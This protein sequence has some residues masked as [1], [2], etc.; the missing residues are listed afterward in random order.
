[1]L[2]TIMMFGIVLCLMVCG[3]GAEQQAPPSTGL[4][5]GQV[6]PDFTVKDIQGKEFTL[7]SLR[8][9]TNVCLVFWATWCPYCISEV[10]KLKTFHEKY[11]PDQLR[12]VSVNVASNDPLPRVRAYRDKVKIPYP[13]LYDS[14]G[15]ISRSY[16]VQG[17]PVSIVID[18]KGIIR[19]RGFQL[20]ENIEQLF[21]RLI[22]EA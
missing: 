6:A 14:E 5:Q 7:S 19:H 10:P 17:I 2:K 16:G 22:S 13:V 15:I 3:C 8:S 21:D 20:P 4:M 12:I 9:K 18:R 1:M 11:K